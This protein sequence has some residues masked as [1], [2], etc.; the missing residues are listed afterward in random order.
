ML[1]AW[2]FCTRQTR[3]MIKYCWICWDYFQHFHFMYLFS[4]SSSVVQH[5]AENTFI[6]KTLIWVISQK[7]SF[8]LTALQRQEHE[9]WTLNHT[10]EGV[11]S[12]FTVPAPALCFKIRHVN[13][14]CLCLSQS[15]VPTGSLFLQEPIGSLVLKEP[16]GS[17]VLHKPIGSHNLYESIGMLV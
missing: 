8:H 6:I 13:Y 12:L 10:T 3:L 9:I 15:Y 16:I 14:T 2:Q 1:V 11:L 17:F 7:H 5:V 4:Q